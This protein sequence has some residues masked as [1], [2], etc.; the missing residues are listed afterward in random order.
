M[1]D[2]LR[3]DLLVIGAGMSGL[4][5]AAS[6]AES[7]ARVGVIEKGP[8][9]GGSAA[10][11]AGILWT[12]P[13]VET[14]RRYVPHGDP[15]LGALIVEGFEDA[16]AWVRSTGVEM[17]QRSTGH[18]GVGQGGIGFGVGYQLD[19]VGLFARWRRTVEHAG[20]WVVT[21]TAAKRLLTDDAGAVIGVATIGPDGPIEVLADAVVIATGGYVNDPDLLKRWV[22]GRT[23]L[24]LP[25]ANPH[26]VGDG[27]RM[28]LAVGAAVSRAGGGFYGHLVGSPAREWQ[29]R[30]FLPTTQYH[31]NRCV[32]LN[33]LGRRF[34]DEARGDAVNTQET[35]RQ[36]DATAILLAD[37]RIRTRYVVASPYEHG[38]VI[39]RFATAIDNGARYATAGSIDG[40]IEQLA[41]WGIPAAN[42]RSTLHA[43]AAAA[44][45]QEVELDAPVTA[46]EPLREPPFHALQVQ[47]AITFAHTGLRVDT[48]ARVLDADD[49]PIAGLL[50]AGVDVGGFYNV[51]Y[52]GG[53]A[54]SL[55]F[56]RRAAATAL[57]GQ[58]GPVAAAR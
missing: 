23:D 15:A 24:L 19:V 2:R 50:A 44:G 3:V 45:G 13:D 4:S 55:V 10:M 49:R 42:V 31:S 18:G 7:G 35:L 30:H 41:A 34:V 56:G 5:A 14:L 21:R 17:S 36:P 8:A 22:G 25:R 32:L 1:E 52:A 48:D 47:P 37:E 38:E 40:L 16:A 54:A 29:E 43:Y 12:A 51:G 57:A 28:A 20:G 58:V 6:A 46:P 9:I 11:S 53:L 27:I 39:D 26:S 33:L